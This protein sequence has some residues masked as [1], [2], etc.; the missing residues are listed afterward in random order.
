MAQDPDTNLLGTFNA[1]NANV[2]T[3]RICKT[4]YLPAPFSGILLEQQ[5]L[6]LAEVWDRLLCAIIN[7]GQEVDC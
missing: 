6:M 2:E 5:D 7:R 1:A 4:I 3:L